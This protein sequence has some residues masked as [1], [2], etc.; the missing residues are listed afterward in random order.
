MNVEGTASTNEEGK[1]TSIRY[2]N[3]EEFRD[4]LRD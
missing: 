3:A 1:I 2:M 4:A